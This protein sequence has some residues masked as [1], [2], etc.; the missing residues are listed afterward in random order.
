[1]SKVRD[2]TEFGLPD[3]IINTAKISFASIRPLDHKLLDGT[4]VSMDVLV[5]CEGAELRFDFKEGQED[6]ARQF[7]EFMKQCVYENE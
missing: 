2:L 4:K 1:M 6:L 7:F 5:V 3:R